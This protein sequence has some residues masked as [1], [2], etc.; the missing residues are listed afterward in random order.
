MKYRYEPCPRCVANG[1]DSRGDNLVVYAN[2]HSHCFACNFHGFPTHYVKPVEVNDGPKSV[3]PADF[4]REIP[5]AAW[6]WVL[7]YGLPYTYWKECAG[8]SEEKGKR[9]VFQVRNESGVAFSIGR[10]IEDSPKAGGNTSHASNGGYNPLDGTSDGRRSPEV[11]EF[12]STGKPVRPRKWYVWGDSHKHCEVVGRQHEHGPIVLVEDI[13]SAHKV[14]Q[15]FTSVPLF[16]TQIHPCHIY[17][18]ANETKDVSLWLDKDQELNVKKQA[19]RLESL[20]SKPVKIVITDKDPKSLSY[21]EIND[22]VK[23]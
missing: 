3:R 4:T 15:V 5:A 8:Y 12:S 20:I 16:G 6:K 22:G 21:E 13:V 14:G 11:F 7:Q 1:K 19:L 17:Y 2:G 9:F 18:L 10:L 23:K